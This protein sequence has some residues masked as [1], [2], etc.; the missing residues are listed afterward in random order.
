MQ[1]F[2]LFMK[3]L[4]KKLPIALIYIIIFVVIALMSSHSESDKGFSDSK[5][6]ISVTDL[7]NTPASKA[8]V[9]Y[10]KRT[11]NIV[12]IDVSDKDN[13][14]DS[15]FY[16]TVD[17]VLTIKQGY[18]E[19]I[20]NGKTDN[21]FTNYKKPDS[22]TS[23]YFENSLNQYVSTLSAYI[24]GGENIISA[25]EKTND[26]ID[27]NVDV[28]IG[29]FSEDE[30]I[31]AVS[32]NFIGFFRTLP[33][34]FLSIVLFVLCPVLLTMFKK[35]VQNR[36]NCSCISSSSQT[37]QIILGSTIFIV[38]VWLIFAVTSILY[39]GGIITQLWL[40]LLNSIVFLIICA[41]IAVFI[42]L[43][44]PSLNAVNFIANIIG[45]G[46][47]FL[48]GVFV[49]Q[50]ML[51]EGVLFVG[52]FFPAFWYTK[53]NDIICQTNGQV[54]NTK[55]FFSCIGI[56]AIFAVVIFA[57]SLLVAKSKHDSSK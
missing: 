15:I 43:L 6:D 29:S 49:P 46:M 39:N 25:V 56:E 22:L 50:D 8:L 23:T 51:G 14:L 7:D 53:A 19:S 31:T 3:I 11:Q 12:E 40:A 5:I 36:T 10:I 54:Y 44:S 18:S 38:A 17:Y 9:D 28:N 4:R 30:A 37:M 41:G 45:L 47:S 21:L 34:I 13:I 2:K 27:Q 33:Y 35:D 24:A 20:Q 55:E 42:A 32:K 48:C 1:V 52:R 26:S 16:E 57:V